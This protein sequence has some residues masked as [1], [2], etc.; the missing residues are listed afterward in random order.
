VS[1]HRILKVTQY[2]RVTSRNRLINPR[3]IP[4]RQ[5]EIIKRILADINLF[6]FI[7]GEVMDSNRYIRVADL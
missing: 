1:L 6:D 4:Y 5:V 2:T 3:H 7:P